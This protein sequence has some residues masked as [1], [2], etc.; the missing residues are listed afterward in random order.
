MPNNAFV[1][2]L[3]KE[4]YPPATR[5]QQGMLSLWS[6]ALSKAGSS[7]VLRLMTAVLGATARLCE[8]T[9]EQ[10]RLNVALAI[11]PYTPQA[12]LSGE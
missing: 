8:P 7:A 10:V 6:L 12:E 2:P 3:N 4:R 11:E 1:I 9:W 5:L